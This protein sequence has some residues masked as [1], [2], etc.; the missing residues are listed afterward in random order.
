[1]DKRYG[2]ACDAQDWGIPTWEGFPFAEERLGEGE[3][4][5]RERKWKWKN[6]K[7]EDDVV[8]ECVTI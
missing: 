6:K 2:S 8:E 5:E 7:T 3:G 4:E 1:L